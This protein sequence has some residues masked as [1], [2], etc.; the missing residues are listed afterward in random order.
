MH[1]LIDGENTDSCLRLSNCR[2]FAAKY[3]STMKYL[4]RREKANLKQ[5]KKT[6]ENYHKEGNS[7]NYIKQYKRH[8]QQ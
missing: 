5:I 6:I 2:Q 3:Q 4:L 1:E 8:I 7:E